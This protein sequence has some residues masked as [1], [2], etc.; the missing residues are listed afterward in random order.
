MEQ[1]LANSDLPFDHSSAPVEAVHGKKYRF[2]VDL[3]KP[4]VAQ[5]CLR[6]LEFFKSTHAWAQC[7]HHT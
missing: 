7:L 6:F 1:Q 3:K 5:V 4:I 2:N